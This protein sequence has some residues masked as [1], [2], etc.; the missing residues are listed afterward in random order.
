MHLQSIRTTQ[1]WLQEL[2]TPAHI[3]GLRHLNPALERFDGATWICWRIELECKLSRLA[4]GR[5]DFDGKRYSI[6]DAGWVDMTAEENAEDPRLCAA[7]G[8]LWLL[9][10]KVRNPGNRGWQVT[11][12]L[13]VIDPATRDLGLE[14]TPAWGRNGWDCEKNWTPFEHNGRLHLHYGPQFGGAWD[15][16]ACRPLLQVGDREI[17]YAFGY[18]SGRSQAHRIGDKY[19]AIGGGAVPHA[20]RGKRY[21]LTGWSIDAATLRIR[22]IGRRPWAWASDD[23]PCLPCPRSIHYNPSVLFSGGAVTTSEKDFLVAVGV[24]DSWLCLLTVSLAE[25]AL[26]PV[27]TEIDHRMTEP[28][29][30]RPPQGCVLVRVG[31]E[32]LAEPGGPFS[33]GE[34]FFTTTGRR[35]ALGPL[36]STIR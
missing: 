23:D 19:V 29:D 12:C 8:K 10:S 14:I 4:F 33:P 9:Y 5:L 31:R 2:E 32:H 25:L 24:H 22:E 13:R 17:R 6:A 11:Q 27:G 34:C 1:H 18:L 28:E 36:V 3:A 26:V 35:D 20:T 21:H 16:E 7:G 30:A 15:V